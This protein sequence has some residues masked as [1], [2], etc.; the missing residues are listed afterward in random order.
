[1]TPCSRSFVHVLWFASVLLS[2]CSDTPG[3][4][5]GPLDAAALDTPGVDAPVADAATEDAASTDAALEDVASSVD[6]PSTTTAPDG[7][8]PFSVGAPTMATVAANG[9]NTPVRIY[10]PSGAERLPLVIFLP[11]FQLTSAQYAG[12]LER[13]ASHGFVVI[14]ADPTGSLFSVSHVNMAVDAAAVLD[15]ALTASPVSARID[16]AHVAMMGHSLGG[17]LSTM[18]AAMDSRVGALM[19]FDPVNGG[20]G[21]SGYSATAPDIVPERVT[22]LTIPIGIA[23]EINNATGGS[24]GMSCAPAAQNYT[25]FYDA[26]TGSGWAAEWT[27]AGADHMDFL[28]DPNCGFTCSVCTDG[29]GDDVA[30]LAI[31]RTLAVAFLR[32]HL[33][34]DDAMTP[35]LLGASVPSGATVRHRP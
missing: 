13:I 3:S 16:G 33:S 14:G 19:L 8:G 11:G 34:G 7:P 29:P 30:Q 20:A 17:K 22:P 24:F 25:T 28:D 23:G 31:A 15:W 9:R 21:P 18:V 6:A 4:D 12:T 2:G 26:A 32:A 1:M 27:L 35:W 5:A 10:Q